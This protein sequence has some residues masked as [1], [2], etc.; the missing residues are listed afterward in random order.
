MSTPVRVLWLKKALTPTPDL[1]DIV[2]D[3]RSANDSITERLLTTII[4]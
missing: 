4:L 2:M 1:V 3:Y